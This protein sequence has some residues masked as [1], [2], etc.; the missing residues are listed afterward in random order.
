MNQQNQSIEAISIADLD[1][2]LGDYE[3][4][5][6]DLSRI[7]ET[8]DQL[9]TKLCGYSLPSASETAE[10]RPSDIVSKGNHLNGTFAS[11][12]SLLQD[13]IGSLEQ[14]IGRISQ[15]LGG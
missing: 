4:H 10:D 15:R 2:I 1:R 14:A 3:N 13:S 7:G 12:I 6:H 9:A 5:L 11:H 8:V